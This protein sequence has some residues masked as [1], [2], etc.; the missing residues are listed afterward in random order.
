MQSLGAFLVYFTVYAQEGF[1]PSAL[2]NLREDWEQDSV[3]DLE[4]SYG[5]EWVR[6]AALHGRLNGKDRVGAW[7]TRVW[8]RGRLFRK[9]EPA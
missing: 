1:W 4:D 6:G 2:V 9:A 7:V 8:P 3:N 5:Q